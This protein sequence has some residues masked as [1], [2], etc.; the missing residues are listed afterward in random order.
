VLIVDG[1]QEPIVLAPP[2]RV[3][4]VLAVRPALEIARHLIAKLRCVVD[5]L[6]PRHPALQLGTRLLDRLHHQ[7]SVLDTILMEQQPPG[8]DRRRDIRSVRAH[9]P[10]SQG[11]GSSS[12][13]TC[14]YSTVAPSSTSTRRIT[15]ACG[16]VTSWKVF[17]TSM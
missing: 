4:V 16:A 5:V 3:P 12:I 7:V 13:R 6:R 11:A 9:A 10:S 14:P 8:H 15:P 2:D 1:A 17:I